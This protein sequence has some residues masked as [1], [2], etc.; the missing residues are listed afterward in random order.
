[1]SRK[2]ANGKSQYVPMQNEKSAQRDANTARWLAGVRDGR[3]V[4]SWR[5]SLPLPT[6]PV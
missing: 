4:I 5:W 3:N 1:M 6:N 2:N